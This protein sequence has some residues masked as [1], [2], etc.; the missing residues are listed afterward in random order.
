MR[1]G[2]RPPPTL[3]PAVGDPQPPSVYYSDDRPERRWAG[4]D[5]YFVVEYT[6][7]D[8]HWGVWDRSLW[9]DGLWSPHDEVFTDFTCDNRGFSIDQ[10]MGGPTDPVQVATCRFTLANGD[11]RFCQFDE[12]SGRLLHFLPGRELLMWFVHD[13]QPWMQFRGEVTRWADTFSD[14]DPRIEGE[15]H[16]ASWR[17]NQSGRTYTPGIHGQHP[18][19]RLTFL[20]SAGGHQGPLD[21]E[22][23][24][25]ELNNRPTTASPLEEMQLTALSDGGLLVMD[26]DGTWR[27]FGRAW[28]AGRPDQPA[29]VVLDDAN[30][31]GY[32]YWGG[33]PV[34]DDESM[35]NV[36]RIESADQPTTGRPVEGIL[37]E[38]Y[39][40]QSVALFG[41]DIYSA[42]EMLWL[43]RSEGQALADHLANLLSTPWPTYENLDFYVDHTAFDLW[44]IVRDMRIG[45]GITVNRHLPSGA[46]IDTDHVIVHRGLDASA[47]GLAV[48]HYAAAPTDLGGP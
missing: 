23:G 33:D 48:F 30:Q 14:F 24:T 36:I 6:P 35:A 26:V 37:V 31:D 22:T 3:A 16:D 4:V 10:Q 18:G 44:P 17:T 5:I 43:T 28:T 29:V 12:T 19:P 39:Q 13:G 7:A 40:E 25:V 38:G 42:H 2:D 9:D 41:G 8:Y 27:Y 47:G 1:T 46:V 20:A 21:F 15:A 11:G 32:P 45:D 34:T